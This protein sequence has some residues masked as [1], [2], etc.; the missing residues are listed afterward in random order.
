MYL[1]RG[2]DGQPRVDVGI[3]DG[4]AGRRT[5]TVDGAEG[6]MMD[7]ALIERAIILAV[8]TRTRPLISF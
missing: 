2:A 6:K 5:V 3:G 1:I 4:V 8:L 7:E